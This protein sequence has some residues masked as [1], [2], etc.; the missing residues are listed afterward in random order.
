MTNTSTGRGTS[1]VAWGVSRRRGG[2]AQTQN[3]EGG[4]ERQT[5]IEGM[6]DQGDR[7][8]I[9]HKIHVDPTSRARA[10]QKAQAVITSNEASSVHQH[11]RT[12]RVQV[13]LLIREETEK[14]IG[15]K[16]EAQHLGF[17]LRDGITGER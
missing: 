6:G 12:V 1:S 16:T 2:R 10:S 5:R 8:Q 14:L 7:R 9:V 15:M 13:E 4:G 11:H 17:G 3:N